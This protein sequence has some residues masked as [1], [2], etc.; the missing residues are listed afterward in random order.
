MLFQIYYP[1]TSTGIGT[2]VIIGIV[3][4]CCIWVACGIF[5]AVLAKNKFRDP[6]GWFFVG[7][8]FGLFALIT[9][10]CLSPSEKNT[11]QFKNKEHEECPHC[12]EPI[13]RG[14]TRCPHCQGNIPRTETSAKEGAKIVQP[15][16]YAEY[17]EYSE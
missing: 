17:D 13:K 2:G 4:V 5:C 16:E 1:E 10:A 8:L 12:L 14:A 9:I 3:I 7:V 15:S 11:K 6:I